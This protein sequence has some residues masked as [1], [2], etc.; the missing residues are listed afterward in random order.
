LLTEPRSWPEGD[1]PRRAAVSAFGVSGTNAHVILEAPEAEPAA[2]DQP[3]TPL[4][5]VPWFVSARDRQALAAQ[6]ERLLA[7]LSEHPGL[8]AADLGYSL[9]TTRT[10]HDHRVALTGTGRDEL[11]AALRELAAD[12]SRAAAS[13][14]SGTG[15]LGFVFSGQ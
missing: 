1:R 15:A 3:A 7:H 5:A 10:L 14:A 6:A 9:A 4:P 11:Q 12:P 2:Q 8:T 13:S